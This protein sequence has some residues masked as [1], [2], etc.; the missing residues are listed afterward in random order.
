MEQAGGGTGEQV[1]HSGSRRP[2]IPGLGLGRRPRA[3]FAPS[4]SGGV[5]APP[6]DTTI[7]CREPADRRKCRKAWPDAVRRT[8][9]QSAERRARARVMGLGDL[10]RSGDRLDREASHR[11][12]RIRTSACRRSAPL[13]LSGRQK[14]K[15]YARR[16]PPNRAAE[17]W[18]MMIVVRMK[19]S[20]SRSRIDRK[21]ESRITLRSM[22]AAATAQLAI[23]RVER[24]VLGEL[25]LPA[26]A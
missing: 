21:A 10:R 23:W 6:G 2:A 18:L 3:R 12:R 20:G 5:G 25:A 16:P 14:D 17:L 8:P 9:Q 7:P 11:V 22:R 19:R 15:G 26:V 1:P 4:H 24:D 13:I